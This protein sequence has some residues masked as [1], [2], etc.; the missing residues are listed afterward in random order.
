MVE[1]EGQ[2]GERGEELVALIP[3]VLGS[4]NTSFHFIMRI[5]KYNIASSRA[6][7]ISQLIDESIERE[8]VANYEESLGFG[9]FL[10]GT[11]FIK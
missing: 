11:I 10:I 2:G 7:T 3:A 4:I 9:L 6:A 5:L 1:V 8:V